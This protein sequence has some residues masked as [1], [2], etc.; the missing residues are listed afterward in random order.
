M[1]FNI[2]GLTLI[3]C[4][5]LF[6]DCL[7]GFSEAQDGASLAVDFYWEVLLTF[8]LIFGQNKRSWSLM[9]KKGSVPRPGIEEFNPDVD[10]LLYGLCC[11]DWDDELLYDEIHAPAARS[12]YSARQD[13]PFFGERLILLQEYTRIL[14]PTSLTTLFYDRRSMSKFCATWATIY[15][16]VITFILTVA[17]V[18]LAVAQVV[19]GFR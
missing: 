5:R 13:F 16:G 10:P 6:R 8:R 7:D 11:Q 4:Y 15:F 2:S 12:A 1:S 18:G 19:S 17:G 3:G 14:E 9:K